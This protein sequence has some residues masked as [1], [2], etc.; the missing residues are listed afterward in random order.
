MD[1]KPIWRLMTENDYPAPSVSHETQMKRYQ[2]YQRVCA[3]DGWIS[4]RAVAALRGYEWKLWW[5][6]SGTVSFNS[7]GG[8]IEPCL[9]AEMMAANDAI[10]ELHQL[11]SD[12]YSV[13][14]LG[15]VPMATENFADTARNSGANFCDA[16][17]TGP[18]DN[19]FDQNICE[20]VSGLPCRDQDSTT[21]SH[22][23]ALVN[24]HLQRGQTLP[25]ARVRALSGDDVHTNL[26]CELRV[27][28]DK[29]NSENADEGGEP[30]QTD[31]HQVPAGTATYDTPACEPGEWDDH[32]A[33]ADIAEDVPDV[34][35]GG[36][37]PDLQDGP[38][39]KKRR[40]RPF[41]KV[42]REIR[43]GDARVH[44]AERPLPFRSD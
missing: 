2:E 12:T 42:N 16:D 35:A 6:G 36:P 22:P 23:S 39:I 19:L 13:G 20:D 37:G 27:M 21:R 3:E 5:T 7:L 24:P 17:N 38:S 4:D 40:G 10:L 34:P 18:L 8:G 14:S 28:T 29:S 26:R 33:P 32:Q 15:A 1:K 43:L 44:S 31:A 41:E 11:E 25:D 30:N 9:Q